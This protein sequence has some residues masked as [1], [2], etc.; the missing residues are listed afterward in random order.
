LIVDE[1]HWE[2]KARPLSAASIG[3]LRVSINEVRLQRRIM[4]AYGGTE[5]QDERIPDCH[6]ILIITLLVI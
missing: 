6:H 3:G 2:P 4:W 1:K 5:G